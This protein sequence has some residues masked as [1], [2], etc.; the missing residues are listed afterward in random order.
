MKNKNIALI[1]TADVGN[2]SEAIRQ[3][4]EYF[5]FTLYTR[6][7]GRPDDFINILSGGDPIANLSHYWIFSSHG[8]EA[9][10]LMPELA[11]ELY[12]PDE[13]QAPIDAQHIRQSAKLNGQT[14]LAT[15]CT[16][17]ELSLAQAFLNSRANA[18]IGSTDYVE[19]NTALLFI[20][21]FFYEIANGNTEIEA[22]ETA[23]KMDEETLLFE[24]YLSMSENKHPT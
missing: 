14:I 1:T 6:Y 13:I 15:G 19:G 9:A 2:E 22:F 4:L 17:G 12:L 5:G 10:F 23:Q 3:S 18:Y 24:C 8:E 7:I 16:L 11:P 20:I 21:R